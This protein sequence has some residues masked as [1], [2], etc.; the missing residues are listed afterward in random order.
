M[1]DSLF[2]SIIFYK[3]MNERCEYSKNISYRII[4]IF[5]YFIFKNN[6]LFT[7]L[8]K[9]CDQTK[10]RYLLFTIKREKP[11]YVNY[12]LKSKSNKYSILNNC[13]VFYKR[14]ENLIPNTKAHRK[15]K[16]CL[17]KVEQSSKKQENFVRNTTK[18][19]ELLIISSSSI[20]EMLDSFLTNEHRV[21][22]NGNVIIRK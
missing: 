6:F 16:R 2:N 1:L 19:A 8:Y 13:E 20:A 22:G 21:R 15:K 4:G 10:M 3:I 18:I 11:Q 14:M 17:L 5:L 9:T 12:E 7:R